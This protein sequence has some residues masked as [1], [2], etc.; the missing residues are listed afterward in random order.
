MTVVAV[1]V[2]AR[3]HTAAVEVEVV[4]EDAA[5]VRTRPVEAVRADIVDRST[6]AEARTRQEYSTRCLHLAPLGSCVAVRSEIA[7]V[8][9]ECHAAWR[10]P[11]VGKKDV[12]CLSVYGSL[13]PKILGVGAGVEE[14][15]PLTSCQR[16]PHASLIASVA[17]GVIDAPVVVGASNVVCP[18]S[19]VLRIFAGHI[20]IFLPVTRC[21][22]SE[23]VD[24]ATVG[25]GDILI[26]LTN[27][28]ILVLGEAPFLGAGLV[29]QV[30]HGETDLLGGGDGELAG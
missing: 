3:T 14:V 15:F 6:I 5:V 4:R 7:R 17:D 18:I 20:R 13:A 10:A 29:L 16:A 1:V 11:S 28:I 26:V 24:P 12:S 9:S 8:G 30:A 21:T 23:E 22:P 27:H 25:R 2:V 19:V